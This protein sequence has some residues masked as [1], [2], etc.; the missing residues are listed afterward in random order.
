MKIFNTQV[1]ASL[2]ELNIWTRVFGC[3]Y[4]FSLVEQSQ[5]EVSINLEYSIR[6]RLSNINRH[7]LTNI[8]FVQTTFILPIN[9]GI[10]SDSLT[11]FILP[12]PFPVYLR[13]KS[14]HRPIFPREG[15]IWKYIYTK[16]PFPLYDGVFFLLL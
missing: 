6:M 10:F 9:F 5:S 1:F 15:N 4:E 3:L 2:Y 13:E 7:L 14:N 8:C 11:H 16:K 12:A